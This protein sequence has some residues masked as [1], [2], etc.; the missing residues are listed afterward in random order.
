M[1]R[2][3]QLALGFSLGLLLH[4]EVVI[5]S[6]ATLSV[7]GAVTRQ[8]KVSIQLKR[9]KINTLTL[10]VI[11]LDRSWQADVCLAWHNRKNS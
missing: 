11:R 9:K 5:L 2:V 4:S 10:T 6:A 8:S 7:G 1:K 3:A